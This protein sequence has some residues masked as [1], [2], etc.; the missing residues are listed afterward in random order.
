MEISPWVQRQSLC[1]DLM[2]QLVAGIAMKI[3]SSH[4]DRGFFGVGTLIK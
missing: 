1:L 4:S 3:V 2:A